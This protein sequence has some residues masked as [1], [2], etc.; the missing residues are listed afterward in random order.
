[1]GTVKDKKQLFKVS[2]VKRDRDQLVKASKQVLQETLEEDSP[3][4][5][6]LAD[7]AEALKKANGRRKER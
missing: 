6:N 5:D 1:M 4:I 2:D 7:L 3:G